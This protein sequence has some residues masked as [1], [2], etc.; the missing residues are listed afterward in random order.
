M[1]RELLGKSQFPQIGDS[2]YTLTL[3]PY[4]FYWFEL[5]SPSELAH[6]V[7]FA[8]PIVPDLVTL[9]MT[10]G[11]QSLVDG[12]NRTFIERD[13]LP[14][15]LTVQRWFAAKEAKDAVTR[16]RSVVQLGEAGSEIFLAFVESQAGDHLDQYFLPVALLWQSVTDTPGTLTPRL[17]AKTR[18]GAREGVLIDAAALP[19]F[20]PDLVRA[21]Q[22]GDCIEMN[23]GKLQFSAT[24]PGK[25]LDLAGV[26][27]RVVGGEQS[28]TSMLIGNRAVTKLYRRI[29][30][31]IHPEIEMGRFLTEAHYGNSPSLLGALEL[32]RSDVPPTALAVAHRFVANQGEA[33]GFTLTYL[34]RVIDE[35]IVLSDDEFEARKD[36]YKE[37]RALADALGR[38]VGE[39]HAA[40]ASRPD[41][42]DFAPEAITEEDL[43]RFAERATDDGL[44]AIAKLRAQ[45]GSFPS[46]V[47]PL[48]S[49]LIDHEKDIPDI[50]SLANCKPARAGQKIRVHGDL[51]LGQVLV[52]QNDIYI[53]DFEGE[54]NRP[55]AERRYKTTP[56]A[57]LS[58][59]LRSF[60]YAA[61]TTILQMTPGHE[62]RRDRLERLAL[63]WRDEMNVRVV[64]AYRS[65]AALSPIAAS[66]DIGERMMR[67]LT[68]ARVFYEIEY[69]IANRPS[70]AIIPLTGARD[71]LFPASPP[72][73]VSPDVGADHAV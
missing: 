46:D 24:E 34:R 41:L 22:R 23:V 55:I 68:A 21:M 67:V 26:E 3:P 70:W 28:N 30:P 48:A 31:G 12:R 60:D 53:V 2:Y 13:I 35:L 38:R 20:G 49:A 27:G 59:L 58:A 10:D 73:Q 57:D 32:E 33:W 16:L 62:P 39:M 17:I 29:E 61:W 51:H 71:L 25:G 69:E 14:P 5:M 19:S 37:Y 8:E 1:P 54:P 65:V 42:P 64:Q 9:V 6:P 56:L 4:G 36:V 52:A 40:L 63:S 66:G 18:F 15:F 7:E 44:K 72:S 43:R 50:L 45:L 11:L 47:A